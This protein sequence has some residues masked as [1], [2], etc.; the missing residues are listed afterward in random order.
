MHRMSVEGFRSRRAS[1]E[2]YTFSLAKKFIEASK[3]RSEC[4]A[5]R[6]MALEKDDKSSVVD[7]N[8]AMTE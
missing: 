3:L 2:G 4:P 7:K 1:N 5:M 6:S 8:I